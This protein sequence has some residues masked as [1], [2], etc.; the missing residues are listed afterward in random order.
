MFL[1][2]L[3]VCTPA[4]FFKTNKERTEVC[5]S[6]W[7]FSGNTSTPSLFLW[8]YGKFE[9]P[10]LLRHYESLTPPTPNPPPTTH[11]LPIQLHRYIN[12]TVSLRC[13]RAG[14]QSTIMWRWWLMTWIKRPCNDVTNCMHTRTHAHTFNLVLWC[15]A[16]CLTMFVSGHDICNSGLNEAKNTDITA[17]DVPP[18]FLGWPAASLCIKMYQE[19]CFIR[20][21]NIRRLWT[22]LNMQICIFN[23]HMN[24]E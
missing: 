5:L 22:H 16:A 15:D 14:V 10:W 12:C 7:S 1:S 18:C 23:Y 11:I 6:L 8:P 4:G 3:Y 21:F 2:D 24:P 20:Y 13:S 9:A 17:K 19:Q